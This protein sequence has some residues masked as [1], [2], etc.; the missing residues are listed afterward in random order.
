VIIEDYV[1]EPRSKIAA[2]VLSTVFVALMFVI[3]ATSILKMS[4][5]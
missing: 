1:H 3:A 5:A 4:L 2:L